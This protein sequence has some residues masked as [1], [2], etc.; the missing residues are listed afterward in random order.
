MA[1]P[2][3]IKAWLKAYGV[4]I[5]LFLAIVLGCLIGFGLRKSQQVKQAVEVHEVLTKKEVRAKDKVI[6]ANLDSIRVQ[7]VIIER[8][9]R[10]RDS[11]LV[12]ARTR[13]HRT[14]SL[15]KRLKYET[16]PAEDI[17]PARVYNRLANYKPGPVVVGTDTL[18]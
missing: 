10:W 5:F 18:Y 11:A 4:F 15:T 9:E 17:T 7:A 6:A 16:L 3:A 14:D 12:E 13:D 1:I 2:L 8:V